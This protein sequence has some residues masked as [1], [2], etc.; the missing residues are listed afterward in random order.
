MQSFIHAL[1]H[2]VQITFFIISMMVLIDFINVMS[3]GNWTKKLKTNLFMQ[4]FIGAF[5]G[6]LPGC[7]G[8]FTISSLYFHD[9][10][11]FGAITATMIAT[12]GDESFVMFALFPETALLLMG[13]L[14][15]IGLF[16]GIIIDLVLKM[17]KSESSCS[18]KFNVHEDEGKHTHFSIKNIKL[19]F[20]K[21]LFP[22]L[23]V[24]SV[25]FI[26]ILLFSYKL[27]EN[28]FQIKTLIFL[29]ISVL[30]FVITIFSDTHFIEDHI[31]KHIIKTHLLRLL[32][33]TG[34]SLLAIEILLKLPFGENVFKSTYLM[35]LI[36][37]LTGLIP[38][39]GPHLFFVTLFAQGMI[40]FS[41]LL[42]SSISQDGHGSLPL[43]SQSKKDFFIIKAINL[44][45]GLFAGYLVLFLGY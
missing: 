19:L 9:L 1:I 31:Y 17:R 26:F 25:I 6:A 29:I 13:I 15:G 11:R 36:A 3:K 22:K 30:F 20:K 16:S 5:L 4:N 2:A 34:A 23:L 12:S 35:V 8:P 7:L 14:F 27:F 21:P 40:P 45:I 32:I 44:V 41:V 24:S 37:A 10:V 38:E 43:L 42:A 33:W 28:E 39:S 18:H